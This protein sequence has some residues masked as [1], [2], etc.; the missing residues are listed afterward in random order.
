[1]TVVIETTLPADEAS[2]RIVEGLLEDRLAA[3]ANWWRVASAYWW[4]GRLEHADEWLVAFK[5]TAAGRDA[6]VEAI[7][8]RHPYDLPYIAWH[9][10]DGVDARYADWV[11]AESGG[12]KEGSS[13]KPVSD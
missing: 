1:M 6:L 4:E 7:R 8:A 12:G 10:P 5:T 11:A 3:C 9:E 13:G 2:Q